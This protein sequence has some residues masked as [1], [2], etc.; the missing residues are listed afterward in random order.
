MQQFE[1]QHEMA[2]WTWY[3]ACASYL[4]TEGWIHLRM[5]TRQFERQ[6]A[7]DT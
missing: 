1:R 2:T 3:A 5:T 7:V 4:S 6:H